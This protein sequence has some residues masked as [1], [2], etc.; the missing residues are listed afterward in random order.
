MNGQTDTAY[1]HEKLEDLKER[2]ESHSSSLEDKMSQLVE[3]MQKVASLQERENN[4]SEKIRELF[5][6][7]KELAAEHKHMNE[8]MNLRME[9]HVADMNICRD[10]IIGLMKEDRA[11]VDARIRDT[12]TIAN[13]AKEEVNKWLNR[14]IGAW[15]IISSCLVLLQALAGYFI[16]EMKVEH[17]VLVQDVKEL[18]RD[19][20]QNHNDIFRISEIIKEKHRE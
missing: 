8:V 10:S 16:K 14:G 11:Q 1:L 5:E 13:N 4:N 17:A 15:L 19:T 2:F 3:L 9:K 20:L 6:S 18:K 7:R 12:S